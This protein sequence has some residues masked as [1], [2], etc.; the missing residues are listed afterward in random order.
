MTQIQAPHTPTVA[1]AT[2]PPPLPLPGSTGGHEE[3]PE[4]RQ[5]PAQHPSKEHSSTKRSSRSE[6]CGS[7]LG[8]PLR[9][10]L[11]MMAFFT[12]LWAV[13]G[14]GHFWPVWPMIGWGMGLVISGQVPVSLP[15]RPT[16]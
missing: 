5:P 4:V 3:V 1:E 10:Y 7:A 15:R 11:V 8:S 14:G 12:V 6:S 16:S 9:T 2:I 13:G